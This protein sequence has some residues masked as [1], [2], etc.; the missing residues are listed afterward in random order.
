MKNI[1]LYILLS[2]YCNIGISQIFYS[3]D[4]ESHP[5]GTT[6]ESSIWQSDG[7]NTASWSQGLND[8]TQ[9]VNSTSVSGIQSLQIL[10]PA[11]EYGTSYTGCQV[12]L[13]FEP[14][15]EVYMSYYLRFSENFSWGTTCHGGKLPGLAG[16]DNCSGG[17]TCD[18]TNGFSCRFMWRTGGKAVLYLYH[19][20]KP[21]TY[22]E[23]IDLV[24]PAG[25]EVIFEPGRWY[26]MMERV[27]INTDGNTYDGEV[28][29]WVNGLLVLLRTGLRF[30]ANGDMVD[31]LYISTFHGGGDETWAP[32]DTCYTYIDDVKIST[33]P[34][35]HRFRNCVGPDLGSNTSL[36]GIDSVVLDGNVSPVNA[37]IVWVKDNQIIDTGISHV[38]YETGEYI[39]VYDS[40]GCV[41]KD[42]IVVGAELHPDLGNDFNL[43]S[44]TFTELNTNDV[45]SGYFCSWTKNREPIAGERS[46]TLIISEAATYTVQIDVEGCNSAIDEISVGSDFIPVELIADA[47]NQSVEIIVSETGGEYAWSLSESMNPVLQIG[48]RYTASLET[49][50]YYLFV[51]DQMSF[52][53]NVGKADI[54]E[55][56]TDNRF[57]RRMRFEVLRTVTIDS[58]TVY[59]VAEQDIVINILDNTQTEIIATRSFPNCTAGKQQLSLDIDLPTGNYYM[60]A[61]GSTGYLRYSYEAD[62]N[63][64]FPYIVDGLL[65][66]LGSNLSWIDAKPYYMYFYNWHISTGNTCAPT[67]VRISANA[68]LPDEQQAQTVTLT[69]GW[70]LVSL[71]VQLEQDDVSAVFPNASIVKTDSLSYHPIGGSAVNSLHSIESGVGYIVYVDQNDTIILAGT[72]VG[73]NA[74]AHLVAGWNLMGIPVNR[75]IAIEEFP[76]EVQVVKTLTLF[77]EPANTESTLTELQAG[78]AYWVKVAGDCVWEF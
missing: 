34:E 11:G 55:T 52:A 64:H 1:L 72:L 36:C 12:P 39:M 35:E 49:D 45:Q 43:C 77:Y 65:S 69:E 76:V 42:T 46:N 44:Q 63:I 25:N 67:P 19:M 56:W 18:G 5:L 4:F 41:K 51:N 78:K 22:G 40:V 37:D 15:R 68:I 60:S 47:N 58:V 38:A 6:Y 8:R 24:W 50:E 61:E 23:N 32:L 62:T 16:G 73:D 66:I 54:A 13:T 3:T 48:N 28:E 10:Y 14:Q 59:A 20:D 9:L 17:A 7:F 71:Y 74:R 21:D 27:K 75:S 29:V 33:N 2:L 31:N 57:D 53:G 70:N 26:H 30:T